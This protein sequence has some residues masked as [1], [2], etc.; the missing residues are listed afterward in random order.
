MDAILWVPKA[1]KGAIPIAEELLLG[2]V[3]EVSAPSEGPD[4]PMVPDQPLN[5]DPPVVT[6]PPVDPV[7][8]AVPPPLE[9]LAVTPPG[10]GPV[11]GVDAL[12][13]MLP[14]VPALSMPDL[15]VLIWP[16]LLVPVTAAP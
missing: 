1:L 10:W 7:P 2:P 6:D 9:A 16:G 8:T 4:L 12:P 11:P 15:P 14:D 3:P 5:L 13:S